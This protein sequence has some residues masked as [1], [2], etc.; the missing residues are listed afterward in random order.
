[1]IARFEGEP[2][3]GRRHIVG[4]GVGACAWGTGGWRKEKDMS[5]GCRPIYSPILSVNLQ[6]RWGIRQMDNP[7]VRVKSCDT[8]ENP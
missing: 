8:P 7:I 2:S 6:R 1:M 4:S 5:R 3:K